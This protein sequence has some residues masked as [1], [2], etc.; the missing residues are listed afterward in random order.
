MTSQPASMT[1]IAFDTGRIAEQVRIIA[2]LDKLATNP[3]MRGDI[4][5]S[6]LRRLIKEHND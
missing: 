5:L 3:P 1:D 2:L 4:A 6:D